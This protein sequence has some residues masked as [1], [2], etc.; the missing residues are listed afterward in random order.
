ME[1][2]RIGWAKRSQATESNSGKVLCKKASGWSGAGAE[3][4]LN[5]QR[6]VVGILGCG[7]KSE[8]LIAP[9]FW[10]LIHNKGNEQ[11][12]GAM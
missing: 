3:M 8:M 4:S 10:G 2:N 6:E 1:R 12:S 5:G 9:T 7:E 11:K